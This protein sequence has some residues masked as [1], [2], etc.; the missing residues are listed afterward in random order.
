MPLG[1]ADAAAVLFADFLKFSPPH[2]QWQDRDRFVLSAGHGSMLLYSLLYLLGYPGMDLAQLKNFRQFG[3]KTPGHPE[4]GRTPGVETTTG[5]LGQGFAAAVGMAIAERMENARFGD[6]LVDHRVYVIAGDGC[7]CEGISHEAASLAGHLALSKLI[8]LFDDNGITIDGKTELSVSDDHLRRFESYGWHAAAVDGHCPE[9]IRAA[10]QNAQQS[11]KPSFIACKTVIGF[12]APN[13]RGSEKAHGSPLGEDEIAAARKELQWPHPPFEIPP[14]LLFAWRKI[15]ACGE[16]T[17]AEWRRR[18]DATPADLRQKWD[19]LR[20]KNYDSAV[21]KT[22]FALKEEFAAEPPNIATRKASEKTLAALSGKI[23]GFIG[24]SADLTGSNNTKVSG[25]RA[26]AAADFGGDYIHY[27]VR[28][29]AM[30]AAMNGLALHGLTPFGGTFLVFSDYCRPAVRL[31]ALMGAHV[32][33]VMT[34]DSIG[35]GEDGPTHQPVEHLAALRAMPGISV[36]RPADAVETA[37]CWEA[38]L[39]DK[40]CPAILALSRQNTPALRRSFGAENLCMRGAYILS[41]PPQRD[42]TILSTGAEVSL[43]VKT[44]DL[45]AADGIRAAVVS[46]PCWER[47]ARQDENYRRKILGDAPRFAVEAAAAF[48]WEKYAPE[49]NIF[50]MPGFGDSAPAADLFA[51]FGF[52]AD[53]LAKKIR[54]RLSGENSEK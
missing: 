30:A 44:A 21:Q 46:L 11:E 1:M 17:E 8:V 28:E 2:P 25:Q 7:L 37:E 9:E 24:G 27:G 40:H 42:L 29:H 12:G 16:I 49:N 34:H 33:Y 41:E 38:A 43:A 32:I 26:G 23:P 18:L 54:A 31:S 13:K 39:A 47:F 6:L 50:S 10:L 22:V 3:G 52:T 51:H 45:L 14:E 53:L 36:Y 35:L 19:A 5:P 15:G 48:G 4:F 20:G